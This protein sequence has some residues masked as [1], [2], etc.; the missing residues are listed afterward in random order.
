MTF[1]AEN[2]TVNEVERERRIVE[3]LGRAVELEGLDRRRFLD[4]ACAGD[5][6]LRAELDAMLE[7]DQD[8]TREFLAQ[9]AV[10][11]LS[12]ELTL[13][14]PES[15]PTRRIATDAP[16]QSPIPQ[17]IGPYR[18]VGTLGQGG[19]GTV[20]LGEQEEP[21]RRRAAVK[22]LDAIGDRRRLQRFAAECQALARLHHPNVAALYEAGTTDEDQ[23]YVAMEPV[24]GTAITLWCDERQLPLRQR[25]ELF[26]G[27][28]A[29]VRHAHEKGILHRDL[30]PANVLVTEIDGRPTAK[31]IDFGIARALGD[32]L[33]SGSTPMTL[34][35]Q[36]VGSPAYMCPEIAAGEREVDTRSDVYSLGLVLYEL[37][38]GVPPFKVRQ[39][40]LV[41]LLRRVA[42]EKR[43]AP[44][45]RYAELDVD[46]QHRIASDRSVDGPRR[47]SRRIRGDLDAIVAKALALD[48]Q[49]RYS[50]PADL[51][52]DLQ[53]HLDLRP[54]AVRA[55]SARYRTGRFV[56]RHRTMA[57]ASSLLVIALVSGI[58][59]TLREARRANLEA[60]RATQALAQSEAVSEFLI[61]LFK[62]ADPRQSQGEDITARELLDRGT[63]QLRSRFSD[64]P[65]S[66]AR[67]MGTI[68]GIYTQLG[69]YER[70]ESLLKAGLAIHEAE[71][72]ADHP[73][74]AARVHE[75]ADLYRLMGRYES[76]EPFFRRALK[77]REGVTPEGGK[78]NTDGI[79]PLDLAQTIRGLGRVLLE[80]GRYQDA[81]PLARRALAITEGALGAD[82]PE[83]ATDLDRLGAVY[84]RQDRLEEAEPLRARALAIREQAL[85]PD[86]PDVAT[87]LNN[88][89]ALYNS[90]GRSDE[91]EAHWQRALAIREKVLGPSHPYVASSLTNLGNL[92]SDQDRLHEAEP[93]LRRALEIKQQTLDP[94]HPHVANSLVGLADL[95]QGQGAF[96]QAEPLMRA[97]VPIRERVFGAD[98]PSTLQAVAGLARILRQL[99]RYDEA[100]PLFERALGELDPSSPPSDPGIAATARD[101][102]LLL[103]ALGREQEAEALDAWL[104]P[105]APPKAEVSGALEPSS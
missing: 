78:R 80:Q 52:S 20:Y 100:E 58:V 15:M 10:A 1:K 51:A 4:G 45:T 77:V 75:L 64:Q 71:L 91:A 62:D 18:I 40:D 61:G 63:E 50:S 86:H 88:L 17:R 72:G 23:P 98:H 33:H 34:E 59:G 92:Y 55:S 13:T 82:H 29:G 70:A 6:G 49:D 93:L 102:G 101:Y 27:V 87:S 48:A 22:M 74:T 68:G 47:L 67:F 39:V 89:G 35:N 43:P 21:V 97:A 104:G 81:E 28:C 14:A 79:D 11:K 24:D 5:P 41:T 9:P 96:D 46:R 31:V 12:G 7:E 56:R 36:I 32:P 25:I 94:N 103:R 37:L 99:R 69:W 54:V 44:S 38:V 42:K 73:Q 84:Y 16:V 8:H 85:G 57:A 95:L 76:A 83:V 30:K 3:L 53:R 65:L 66:K 2:S 90:Q 26:L 19:M 60:Q 105:K